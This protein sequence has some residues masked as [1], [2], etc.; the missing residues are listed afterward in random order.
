MVIFGLVFFLISNCTEFIYSFLIYYFCE[1]Y[2]KSVCLFLFIYTRICQKI[3]D[4]LEQNFGDGL[5]INGD[6]IKAC[7]MGMETNVCFFSAL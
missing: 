3:V 7:Q 4:R 5:D 2:N 1:D 6:G